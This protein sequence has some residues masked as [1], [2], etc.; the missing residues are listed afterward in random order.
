MKKAKIFAALLASVYAIE[1]HNAANEIHASSLNVN[2]HHQH[3]T[4]EDEDHDIIE[5]YSED[6][7]LEAAEEEE[8]REEEKELLD[9]IHG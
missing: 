4:Y 8:L 1:E 5:D 7:E 2:D 9:L 6:L 3:E